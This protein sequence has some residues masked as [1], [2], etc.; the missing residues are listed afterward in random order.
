M[1]LWI[2]EH[3]LVLHTAASGISATPYEALNQTLISVTTANLAI[4]KLAVEALK[5]DTSVLVEVISTLAHNGV[6]GV[7]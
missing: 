6:Q 7:S 1:V 2:K 3:F 4:G 5:G